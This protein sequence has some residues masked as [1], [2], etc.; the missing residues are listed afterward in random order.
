MGWGREEMLY[1]HAKDFKE[2][3]ETFSTSLIFVKL[4]LKKNIYLTKT[5]CMKVPILTPAIWKVFL[6]SIFNLGRS[7]TDLEI[8]HIMVI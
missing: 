6:K 2:Y 8:W 5:L 4:N 1:D 7:T 3:Y